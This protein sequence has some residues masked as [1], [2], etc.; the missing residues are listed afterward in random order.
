VLEIVRDANGWLL[1]FRQ[2]EQHCYGAV[3]ALFGQSA[4]LGCARHQD[5]QDHA[6]EPIERGGCVEASN[7]NGAVVSM[8]ANSNTDAAGGRSLLYS[9]SSTTGDTGTDSRSVQCAPDDES[10]ESGGRHFVITD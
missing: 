9:W 10:G 2:L 4:S 5:P 6:R 3:P 8:N 7:P 1:S